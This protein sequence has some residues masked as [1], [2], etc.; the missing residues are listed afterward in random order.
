MPNF[1]G[2]QKAK[3][4]IILEHLFFNKKPIVICNLKWF[5]DTGLS[6][7][8]L[9]RYKVIKGT[10]STKITD[11]FKSKFNSG[12]AKKT[13]KSAVYEGCIAKNTITVE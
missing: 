10:Y 7:L 8:Y 5:I 6:Y 3:T 11:E 4:R 12:N 9:E 13:I 2:F 1:S